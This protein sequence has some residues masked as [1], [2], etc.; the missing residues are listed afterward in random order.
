[1]LRE[2]SSF[3][4]CA[5][6]PI[7]MWIISIENGPLI[8]LHIVAHFW[9]KSQDVGRCVPMAT[10]GSNGNY[11]FQWQLPVPMPTTGSNGNYRFQWQLPPCFVLSALQWVSLP[12]GPQRAPA[13]GATTRQTRWGAAL[14]VGWLVGKLLVGQSFAGWLVVVVGRLVGSW[15]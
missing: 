15:L 1:M 10:A 6:L 3:D 12:G 8:C 7:R 14:A 9:W 13:W 2:A 5:I 4:R 11:R